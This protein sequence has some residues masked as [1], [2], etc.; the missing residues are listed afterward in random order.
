MTL[1]RGA[2]TPSLWP[3]SSTQILIALSLRVRPTTMT[4]GALQPECTTALATSP[5]AISSRSS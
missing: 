4:S 5:L 1:R 3:G 2:G